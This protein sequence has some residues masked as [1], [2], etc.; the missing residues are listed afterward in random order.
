MG[1]IRL[2]DSGLRRIACRSLPL[3]IAVLAAALL[4]PRAA[5]AQT[6][7][8]FGYALTGIPDF[9]GFIRYPVAGEIPL[10]TI[11]VDF[12]NDSFPPDQPPAYYES[13]LFA[14]EQGRPVGS[15]AGRGG[16]FEENSFGQFR[17]TNAGV[18]GPFRAIDDPDTLLREDFSQCGAWDYT[19][20]SN[21][22][23][24]LCGGRNWTMRNA[25]R[26]AATGFDFRPFDSSGDGRIQRNELMILFVFAL[27]NGHW[28]TNR[29]TYPEG[30]VP[31]IT[32]T[33]GKFLDMCGSWPNVQADVDVATIA[34]EL[35][36]ALGI[37]WE[38]YGHSRN[39]NLQYSMMGSTITTTFRDRTIYHLDPFVKIKLGWILPRIVPVTPSTNACLILTATERISAP[40]STRAII[41]Y[42]PARG[43]TEYFVL[44]YRR[45]LQSNY[46]GDPFGQ[47]SFGLPQSRGMAVWAVRINTNTNPRAV[48]SL[49]S[50]TGGTGQGQDPGCGPAGQPCLDSAIHI[51]PPQ[52][53]QPRVG[54]PQPGAGLW[55]PNDGRLQLWWPYSGNLPTP[56]S[57]RV[58]AT[59][60]QGSQIAVE[61]NN[62]SCAGLGEDPFFYDLPNG[63]LGH[64][65]LFPIDAAAP[66]VRDIWTDSR[67][68]LERRVQQWMPPGHPVQV[69]WLVTPTSTDSTRVRVRIV[70]SAPPGFLPP[71][72][73]ADQPPPPPGTPP[74]LF[75]PAI[76]F[77]VQL[78]DG[79]TRTARYNMIASPQEGNYR[80]LS[81]VFFESPTD[82]ST[83]HPSVDLESFLNVFDP[84]AP[85]I[86]DTPA[87]PAVHPPADITIPTTEAGGAR[88]SASPALA[89]FL[90]GGSAEF[91]LDPSPA[92]LTP[93]V[94]G[95]DVNANTL[96]ALGKTIVTFRF[97][98]ALGHIATGT[99]TVTVAP[100]A[101]LRI[102]NFAAVA[103][104][105]EIIAGQPLNLTLR[106]TITNLGPSAPMDVRLTKTAAPP[107]GATVTPASS[108][109]NELALALN[110]LR[111]VNETFNVQCNAA[112]H[113]LFRF[114]NEI[115][116]LRPGDI[117]SD[118]S[119]N[120]A[121]TTVDLEC[122]VPVRINI[123]P[124][125]SPNS[126]NLQGEIALAILTT[127]AGEY[128]LPLAFDATRIDPLSVRFGPRPVLFPGPGGAVERHR[129]GH[130]EDA[131][132][133][134]E[135][136]RDGDPD[137][138]LHFLASQS[139][140]TLADPEACVKGEWL[141]SSNQRHKFFGCD[142]LVLAPR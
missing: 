96:F 115:Q 79:V 28:G 14:T 40:P 56:I 77:D 107:A 130:I 89:A 137:M 69:Q 5:G 116:P 70:D 83:L 57:L 42:D 140:L 121:E 37:F 47:G 12:T 81:R 100:G 125:S 63:I 110:E 102:V 36:H 139:G 22:T 43:V 25:L 73:P 68:R 111:V 53:G 118:Q 35:A 117:D 82:G 95:V 3:P 50:V 65:R 104:P 74:A 34:H 62:G 112:G 10:L 76:T 135:K 138:V 101:D 108:S 123:K 113:P 141:D 72:I 66:E 142:S 128:G 39:E 80:V 64:D 75:P 13:L 44:E 78:N 98:D 92:R 27:Q 103:P 122:V 99:S 2:L 24:V 134:D 49:D 51:F 67:F 48:P 93:Q 17:F 87:T 129:T 90:A 16:Y 4:F 26:H 85:R 136:T 23:E 114:T 119:N 18:I 58:R 30:C 61:L 126:Y 133:M 88:A 71:P 1:S 7:A 109:A 105:R 106:K 132:E 45:A 60:N 91:A 11:L 124:G 55:T 29:G 86:G 97:T 52:N 59:L 8:S 131:R 38:G 94:S 127:R 31:V 9:F 46:D 6:P 33:P 54:N 21:N 84:N 19:P 20:N 15:V 41:L 120:R 32:F